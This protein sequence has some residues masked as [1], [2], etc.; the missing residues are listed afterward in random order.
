MIDSERLE[1]IIASGEQI[2]LE[3][4]SD[5]KQFPD[6]K[7]YESIVALANTEDC[8]WLSAFYQLSNCYLP[9][10]HK[11]ID[12]PNIS[13]YAASILGDATWIKYSYTINGV[14]DNGVSR[15]ST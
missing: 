7:I 2:D 3:F 15:L 12:V 5:Q 14:D 4:K 13:W 6:K 9:G 8:A 11:T 1:E 10:G